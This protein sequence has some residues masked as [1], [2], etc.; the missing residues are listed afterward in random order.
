MIKPRLWPQIEFFSSGGQESLRLFIQQQPFISS[1]A[2]LEPSTLDE[3]FT[4]KKFTTIER[5]QSLEEGKLRGFSSPALPDYVIL[6]KMF[7]DF[8]V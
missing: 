5:T 7:A 6:D 8:E 3:S 4:F 2:L 1:L